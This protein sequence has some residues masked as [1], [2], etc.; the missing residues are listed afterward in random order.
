ML[1]FARLTLDDIGRTRSFFEDAPGIICD[2]TVGGVFM[3]R[4][5]LATE[6]ALSGDALFLKKQAPY[7]GGTEAFHLPFGGDREEG[8]RSI[9]AYCKSKG[10]P[11]AFILAEEEDLKLLTRLFGKARIYQEDSWSD[12][13]YRAEDLINLPGKRY[14]GQKNHINYFKKTQE[15][16]LFEEITP[17]NICAVKEFF[18]GLNISKKSDLLSE[19]RKKILEVLDNYQAYGFIGGLLRASGQIAAFAA[20]ERRGNVLYV[21]IE[22]ADT[23]VRGAYQMICNEFAGHYAAE[24]VDYINREEDEGDEGLRRSKLSYHPCKIAKK[25]I[26]FIG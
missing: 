13:I 17:D 14:H 12:Y 22:K 10:S 9:A 6:Y 24:G 2:D 11:I 21:H 8:M 15:G 19:E 7:M 18:C 23:R 3:W 26:A 16:Y 20:G 4:D 1:Q 25:Y 5:Y